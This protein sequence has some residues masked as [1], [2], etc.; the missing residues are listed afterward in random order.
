MFPDSKIAQQFNM[1]SKKLSY[2]ISHGIGPYFHRDLVKQLK[3]CEKFVLCIDEQTNVQNKKQLDLLVKFWSYDEGLVVTRYFKSILLGHAQANVLQDAIIN[4]FKTDGI[5]LKRLLMLGRDN[6]SVNISLE[7]LIDQEMKKMGSGLLLVGSCNLH[8]VHNGF[9]T[10]DCTCLLETTRLFITL[11][12]ALGISSAKWHVENICTE[13]YSW[14]KQSPARKEDLIDIIDEFDNLVEKTLLY[15][16]I[17]RW[18]LLGKVIERVL[19]RLI[20]TLLSFIFAL[21]YYVRFFLVLW[22]P[23]NEYFLNFLP[24]VQKAQIYKNDK[25]EKIKSNLASNVAKIRLQFVLF[26]CENIFDRFLT[27]FQQEGPLIHLLHHE[28]SELFHLVLLQFLKSDYVAG[29]S[30]GDLINL[31]FKLNEKQLNNKQIRIGTIEN[32]CFIILYLVISFF[33]L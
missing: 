30:G 17:T 25:Y 20:D 18:I 32:Y 27:W 12:L 6:P 19:S 16:T 7:N 13:I 29:K 2:V 24:V 4:S 31:D 1:Q 23:L 10:G 9:K 26:L 5:D 8:V 28:L 15:F 22:E 3:R 11:S 21:K 33:Y 14:F